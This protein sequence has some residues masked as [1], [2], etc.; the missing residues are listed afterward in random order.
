MASRSGSVDGT[1]EPRWAGLVQAPAPSPSLPG[2][3][4]GSLSLP[5]QT[6]SPR[7]LGHWAVFSSLQNKSPAG[8]SWVTT[9]A[10]FETENVEAQASLAHT[11]SPSK[12]WQWQV[13]YLA[14]EGCPGN[15][16]STELCN[17]D[18]CKEP[19][20]TVEHHHHLPLPLRLTGDELLFRLK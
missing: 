16:A 12:D 1:L 19:V 9:R 5:L 17:Q 8:G 2:T 18:D 6:P 4:T 7:L 20:V 15:V 11:P 3:V 14:Q 13:H 10:S